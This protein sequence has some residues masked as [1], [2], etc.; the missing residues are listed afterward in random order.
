MTRGLEGL[1]GLL[2]GQLLEGIWQLKNHEPKQTLT[3]F[4]L[5]WRFIADHPKDTD[6]EKAPLS[7]PL[8]LSKSMSMDVRVVV[9]SNQLFI[10]GSYTETKFSK[11]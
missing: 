2:E 11:K 7:K 1:E 9:M 4:T 6:R 10:R 3:C 5:F 8:T